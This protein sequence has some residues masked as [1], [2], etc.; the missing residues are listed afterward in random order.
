MLGTNAK[1]PL[2]VVLSELDK[3]TAAR[4]AFEYFSRVRR[5]PCALY[6]LF[7]SIF[8]IRSRRTLGLMDAASAMEMQG[9]Q[10]PILIPL[11]LSR[12]YL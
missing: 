4:F 7:I 8:E 11:A 1:K 9:I 6:L 3:E 2:S 12:I 5:I 10:T